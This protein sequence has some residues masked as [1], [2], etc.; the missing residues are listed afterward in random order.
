[1][2]LT[3]EELKQ[4]DRLTVNRGYSDELFEQILP[5]YNMLRISA[6][7]LAAMDLSDVPPALV[8]RAGSVR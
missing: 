1:M 5:F 4:L 6:E 7:K 3:L 8:Y 2:E